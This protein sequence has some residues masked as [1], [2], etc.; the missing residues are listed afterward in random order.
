LFWHYRTSP[1]FKTPNKLVCIKLKYLKNNSAHLHYPCLKGSAFS[2]GWK[3]KKQG[4]SKEAVT[5]TP[6]AEK[7]LT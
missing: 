2:K 6:L 3:K 1:E 7:I 5:T 4:Q